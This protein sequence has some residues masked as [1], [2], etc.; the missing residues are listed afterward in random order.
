LSRHLGQ[1][2][3][4]DN[5]P[6]AAGLIGTEFVAN[7]APDGYTLTMISSSHASNAPMHKVLP[8]H[9]VDSFVPV[10]LYAL[11]PQVLLTNPKS[12]FKTIKE[13]IAYSKANPGKLNLG[14]S[15]LGST[16][17][18]SGE[19]LQMMTGT[20]FVHIPYKGGGPA[21]AALMAGEIDL[22]FVVT[23]AG[24]PHV[25]A[26]R[27]RALGVASTERLPQFP[28]VPTIAE[29]GVPGYEASNWAGILAPAGTPAAVVKFIQ[30]AV[31]K[32]TTTKAIQ[33]WMETQ[34]L[35]P[36]KMGTE[37]FRKILQ[38]EIAQWT[39]VVKNA[40]IEVQ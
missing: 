18:L 17:H 4:V 34:G 29:S 2:I 20:K 5:K 22:L 26:G 24:K 6:G 32:T 25:D 31:L 8:Y 15:G 1:N 37:E 33:E 27:L 9:P 12:P 35:Q 39:K 14:S 21:M 40:G 13:M 28:G 3:V 7:A 11:S 19:L 36:V 30:D 23:Q 10:I 38:S 16:P